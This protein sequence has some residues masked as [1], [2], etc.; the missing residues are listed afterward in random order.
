MSHVARFMSQIQIFLERAVDVC[1]AS[2]AVEVI[3]LGVLDKHLAVHL[4]HQ[5]YNTFSERTTDSPPH[6][7]VEHIVQ[8]VYLL[9]KYSWYYSVYHI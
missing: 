6:T 1:G 2:V 5:I 7:P 9:V 3:C 8:S 4:N